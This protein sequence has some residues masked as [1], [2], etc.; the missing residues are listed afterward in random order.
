MAL[1]FKGR[2]ALVTG[3][4]RG[5]GRALAIGLAGAGAHVIAVGRTTGALEELD[6]EIVAAGGS[7]TLA[8]L[9]LKDGEGIDRLGKAVLE[10]WG[11]LD[12]LIAN[13]GI[14]GVIT[15]LAHMEEKTFTDVM[16]VNVTA[17]WRLI[18]ALDP[19]LRAAEAG[20]VAVL[21]SSAAWRMRP[22]WGA[23]A[24]SKAA[25]EVLARTYAEET[26]TTSPVVVTLV[27]PGATRTRM[28]AAAMPGEDPASVKTPESIVPE[29]LALCAPDWRE[30]GKLWD[31]TSGRV[32]AHHEP[33]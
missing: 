3:A 13:A 30:T 18:R 20:R 24:V 27:N 2:V 11:R 29:I 31:C 12:V 6:D 4:T 28:R 9:D 7:A 14:L 5:I 33:S 21:S 1:T 8:P 10:R 16:A 25:V 17:N 32:L 22:Y 23:Y 19:A 15:P 26:R